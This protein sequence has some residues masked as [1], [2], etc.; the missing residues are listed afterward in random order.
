MLQPPFEQLAQD[1][2]YALRAF[3]RAPGFTA[4]ALISLALG[5]GANTFIFSVASALLLRPL[6]YADADRLAILWNRSPGLGIAEDWFSTAQYFDIKI[7]HGG[8]EQVAIAIGGNYNLTGR[9]EPER[10]GTIR[11]SSNL[12]PMLGV[13]PALGR[14]LNATDDREGASPV[15][16]LAHGTWM[17]RYGGDPAMVGR[18]I[19]LNGQAYEIAGV[20]PGTFSLPREVMPTLYGAE[21]SEIILPLPMPPK[22]AEIRTHEDY[23]IVGKLKP[24]VSL[25]AA[26]A[27]MDTITAR[28][29]RDHPEVYPPNGGLTFSVIPLQEQVV[30]NVRRSLLIL[31]AAVGL[32]LLIACANVANLLL[33]RTL[34]RQ[35]ELAVR[36]ALGA[37][38]LRIVSQLLTESLLLACAGGALGIVLSL[39][40]LN[41]IRAL[42][43][44]SV[45]RLREIAIDNRVLLFTLLLSVASGLVFGLLPSLRLSRLDVQGS[46]KDGGRGSSGAGAM[47]GRGRGQKL[48]RLLVMSQ[49]ALSVVLLIGAG[50]LIRSFV[51]LQQVTPGF[52]AANVLTLELTLS[53]GKYRDTARVREAYRLLWTRL[54]Q[55]PGVTAAGGVSALPLS[56]MFA[57]GP[58][59]VEGRVPPPGEKFINADIRTAAGGY[60]QAMQIPL[61][62]GRLF[63]DQDLATSPRVAVIDEH[64]ARQ[65][66]PGEDALGKRFRYS[67]AP[68]ASGPW[69]TIVGIVG[70]VKQY[71]LDEESRI[72]FYLPHE[73][74][75]T[76]A[77]NVVL[78][79]GAE[80]SAL[81]AALTAAVRAA[82]REMD[83]D[84]P[85]Y[86]V[87]TME[88]RV[89]ESLAGRRFSMLLLTLFAGL[90]LG[91]ATIGIYG[92]MAYLVS[93]GTRELG[94]RL[95]L[96]A[97][98]AGLLRLIVR[99]GMAVATAG[100]AV[101]L[102]GA[103]LLTRFMDSLLFGVDA[104]DPITYLSIA[105]LLTAIALV[106]SWIPGRRAARV[107]PLVSLRSE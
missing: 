102:A 77:M 45:P 92:V 38:R 86:G 98:P 41:W 57:W 81:A 100:V 60:F 13:R 70:R 66:W 89:D 3:A 21:Q 65:L 29:R 68:D 46:L 2:R 90:A 6:P 50:L 30:G 103:F 72:A 20:L 83:A 35:K 54:A 56:Q 51:R 49:L 39:W 101:G 7:G 78:R 76:R 28:L 75:G 17:R 24:G 19:V 61:I 52:T 36:A 27:E 93:Q 31:S 104:S 32:V 47:W 11:V 34:G 82:I 18:S 22:A 85:V 59:A 4:A 12:L 91:I 105:G 40:S 71:T 107:D 9:G 106:A 88:A 10:I 79:G 5:V 43:S 62:A 8:F 80:P 53:G 44:R 55:L 26:Q 33:A 16:L 95:A 67:G 84:L 37:S 94:I 48:R 58:I 1:V 96:G 14:L 23:N 69:I 97:T 25:A 73:Q 63:T 99:Q 42:G 74:S 64:M 15:A 87:R